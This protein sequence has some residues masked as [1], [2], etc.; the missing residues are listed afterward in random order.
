MVKVRGIG[1]VFFKCEDTKALAAWY[2]KYL[3]FNISEYGLFSTFKPD[4]M[5]D[6]GFT[7]WSPFKAD[8]DYFG[9]ASQQFMINLIVDD[10][11]E[12]L[13]QVK[14]GGA[15]IVGDVA[16]EEYGVFGWFM[17][18]AGFKVELWTPPNPT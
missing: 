16:E 7:L 5:P 9:S 10:V 6:Q 14:E 8:S 12:A 4:Q 13:A 18:P 3:G 1:G 17:D 15:E 2:E 11:R